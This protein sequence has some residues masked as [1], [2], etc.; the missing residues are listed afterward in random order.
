MRVPT[1]FVL[2]CLVSAGPAAC[3]QSTNASVSGRVTDQTGGVVAGAAL[4]A[5]G[6]ETNLRY[7]TTTNGV[8]EYALS[9]LPPGTYRIEVEKSGFKKIVKR[10]VIVHVQDALAVDFELQLAASREP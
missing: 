3:A 1:A 4:A 6:A 9:S 2:A 7:A 10:D 5:V 8:G